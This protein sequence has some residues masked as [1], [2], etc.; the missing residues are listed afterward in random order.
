MSKKALKSKKKAIEIFVKKYYRYLRSQDD[1]K[2][3]EYKELKKTYFAEELKFAFQLPRDIEIA[4]IL[5]LTMIRSRAV[6]DMNYLNMVVDSS[7]FLRLSGIKTINYS[8]EFIKVA[9]TFKAKEEL[10][11]LD[12]F[13]KIEKLKSQVVEE[14]TEEIQL[15]INKKK[16]EY[17]SL[18][19][20]LEEQE[21]QEPEVIEANLAEEEWWQELNLKENPFP[22]AL[23]GLSSLN[24]NLFNEI[25]VETQP[26]KWALTKLTNQRYEFF[27][28]A[29][30]L[31]GDF[32]SGK[33]TF[34]DFISLHL[35]QYHIEPLRIA[36]MD[37]MSVA[38]YANKFETSLCKE[39]SKLASKRGLPF[40]N[41]LIDYEEMIL[42]M[43]ELQDQG[44][45]GFFLFLDDLHKNTNKNLV[46]NFLGQLQ[47][48]KNN[49]RNDNVNMSYI[50]SGFPTWR[51]RIKQDSGLSGFFD[52]ADNLSLPLVTPEIAAEAIT[53]RLKAF[54]INPEKVF[55]IRE[56]FLRL[57]FN[58]EAE[59]IGLSTIG[60]RPY[61]KAALNKFEERKYDILSVD[62]TSLDA[63]LAE[64][65]KKVLNA[66]SSFGEKIN[67]L[68]YGGGISTKENRE[69]ALKLLCE[70][71]LRKGISE[72]EE[73]FIEHKFEMK[74]LMNVGFIQKA[75]R[76][77]H[78]IWV[79][80]KSLRE[81]NQNIIDQYN[82]SIEDYLV[83]LYAETTSRKIKKKVIKTQSELYTKD[84]KRWRVYLDPRQLI[85]IESVLSDYKKYLEPFAH[86]ELKNSSS[87]SKIKTQHL[88][89]LIDRLMHTLLNFESPVLLDITPEGRKVDWNQRHRTLEYIT[90]FI[91]MESEFDHIKP[92]RN[93]VIRLKTFANDSFD[94]L[95]SELRRAIEI[96]RISFVRPF[97]LPRDF[98]NCIY[99]N[100]DYLFQGSIKGKE[101]FESVSKLVELIE[102]ITRSYLHVCSSLC[103]GS[104]EKRLNV[105]PDDIKRYMSKGE[106]S[107]Q[108]GFEEQ[109]EFE[110]LNRGQYRVLFT[111]YSKMNI[112]CKVVVTPVVKNWDTN[113]LETFF[114]LFGDLNIITS[115]NKSASAK[116]KSKDIPT[117]F[118]LACRFVSDM[119]DNLRNL[120]LKDN[121]FMTDQKSCYVIF[122]HKY[123]N[124]P[125]QQREMKL[126]DASDVP[127]QFHW[128]NID[129]SEEAIETRSI[130]T[131]AD[132]AFG[133][134][135]FDMLDVGGMR[136]R[137]AESFSHTAA[138]LTYLEATKKMNAFMIYGSEI[139]FRKSVS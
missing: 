139:C 51:D 126:E 132:N 77:N 22:G 86:I 89:K 16:D 6:R 23:E 4:D 43:L 15:E 73:I 127:N 65:I 49:L 119:C 81:L 27:N 21:F 34:F 83:P 57:V 44:T 63:D 97:N 103:F 31:A 3:Y 121:F 52:A 10:E 40:T 115:H 129:L 95:W 96:S 123:I 124:Y 102:K 41:K 74:K 64:N 93:D 133:D 130:F 116:D 9:N 138:M 75:R 42:L 135:L 134:I 7:P 26:I 62:Y 106:V 104:L 101:Y 19:S 69:R 94:E 118:R 53:K 33:T 66:D 68:I 76:D 5:L 85:G 88:K 50:V 91:Q 20:I 30:L 45:K 110:E 79:L 72:E 32:G 70:I 122:G 46:F 14:A 80:S 92:H 71:Y 11:N 120:L 24:K 108:S 113:D 61:I 39:V 35:L 100:F 37:Q 82:L 13:Q 128:H 107:A 2:K 47:I 99:N 17:R 28:Q 36:M 1:F 131:H 87:I 55:D 38:H 90:H 137:F 114:R 112:F 136:I 59:E 125:I 117:F 54:A 67:K 58:N 25:I 60:F 105:Y 78:L 98:I 29:F 84:I 48:F 111:Q 12:E 18:P 109:N 56:T 8:A